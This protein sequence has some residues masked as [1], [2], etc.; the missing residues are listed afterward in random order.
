MLLR[1]AQSMRSTPSISWDLRSFL[2][3][4][5][6]AARSDGK[7]KYAESTTRQHVCCC[8]LEPASHKDGPDRGGPVGLTLRHDAALG[9][10]HASTPGADKTI[11]PFL[12]PHLMVNIA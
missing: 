1:C 12:A 3:S 9:W 11:L 5:R 4:S 10:K 6:R 2:G 8:H 7:F